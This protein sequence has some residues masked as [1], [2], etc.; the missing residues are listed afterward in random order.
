MKKK[1]Q[2]EKTGHN[3]KAPTADDSQQSQQNHYASEGHNFFFQKCDLSNLNCHPTI[4]QPS[5]TRQRF[6]NG[7]I[8]NNEQYEGIYP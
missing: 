2:E 3:S 6:H 8:I 5:Q 4:Q 1:N 7:H